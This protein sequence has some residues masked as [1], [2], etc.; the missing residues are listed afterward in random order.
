MRSRRDEEGLAAPVGGEVTPD[1]FSLTARF[2][3]E[4]F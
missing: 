3:A 4:F 1:V 2:D